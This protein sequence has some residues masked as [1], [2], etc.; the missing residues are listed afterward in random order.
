MAN[1]LTGDYEAV[2]QVSADTLNRLLASMHQN[3]WSNPDN[4]SFP[5]STGV[6]LGDVVMVDGVRGTAWAQ[7]GVPRMTLIDHATDRFLI[8]VGLRIRYQADEDTEPLPTY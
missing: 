5:H 1:L 6:R 7:A 3:A 2:L 8:E 4:P